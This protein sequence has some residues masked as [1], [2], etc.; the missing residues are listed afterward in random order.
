MQLIIRCSVVLVLFLFSSV[1]TGQNDFR[2]GSVFLMDGDTIH[3]QLNF[4]GDLNHAREIEFR[5]QDSSLVFSPFDILGYAFSDGKYYVSKKAIVSRDTV[6][7]FAEYLVKGQK[8]LYYHRSASGPHY[9]IDYLN[10]LITEIPY[11]DEFVNIDVS[12]TNQTR[13]LTSDI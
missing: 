8:N 7:I 1:L 5:N 2:S 10:G 6:N 13:Q 12:T 4:Q 3:G 9:L 11:N